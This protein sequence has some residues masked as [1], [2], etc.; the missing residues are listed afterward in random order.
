MAA[1]VFQSYDLLRHIYSFGDPDHRTAMRDIAVQLQ[2]EPYDF[3]HEYAAHKSQLSPQEQDMYSLVLYLER[4]PHDRLLNLL[5]RYK[6]CYCC[7]RHN[8]QKPMFHHGQLITFTGVVNET[9]AP[10]CRCGCRHY[11]RAIIMS[12]FTSTNG[13][14]LL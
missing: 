3:G 10:I 5:T 14:T 2:R 13:N 7:K 8:T 1:K 4:L 11:S 12:L 9:N 6:R